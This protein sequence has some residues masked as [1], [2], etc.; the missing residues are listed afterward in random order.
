MKLEAGIDALDEA[1]QPHVL[2]DRSIDTAIDR[3]A[4]ENEGIDE[5]AR[6]EQRVQREVDARPAQWTPATVRETAR[7][8]DFIEGELRPF[9]ARI[10]AFGP[11]VHGVGAVGDRRAYSVQRASWREEFGNARHWGEI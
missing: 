4:E 1:H 5:L 9:I 7:F 11:E 3:L 2:H 6:L 8:G 10:E